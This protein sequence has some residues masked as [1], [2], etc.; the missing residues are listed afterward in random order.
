MLKVQMRLAKI[1]LSIYL[2]LFQTPTCK[3]QRP[4]LDRC[5]K[6]FCLSANIKMSI[7]SLRVYSHY[8]M[9]Y[10]KS[11]IFS[12]SLY[13]LTSYKEKKFKGSVNVKISSDYQILTFS[14]HISLH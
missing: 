11:T 12:Y 7:M 6:I 5:P 1:Y 8:V 4:Q 9:M 13:N 2:Y 3:G 14:K 10:H